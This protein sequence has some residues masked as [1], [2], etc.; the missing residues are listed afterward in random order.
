VTSKNVR[1]RRRE[2]LRKSVAGAALAGWM[3]VPRHV[4]GGAGHTPPSEKL[5]IA[6]IG[7][8][9]R[10]YDDLLSVGS[11]NVVALC[12]VD[13]KRAAPTFERFPKARRYHDFRKL[14]DREEKSIDAV[15]VASTDHTHI[16]ASVMAMKRGK[17][18][19]CEKPMGHD[20]YEVRAATIVARRYGVATQLGNGAHSG[21]NYRS[22]VALIKAGTIGEVREVHAWCDQSWPPGD[23]PKYR[24]PV[25]KHL[26]WD[27]WLGPAP[28]RPYHPTYHPQG[29]RYW[30][31]FG[32]G[33]LGDMGCHMI[34]LPFSALDLKYPLTVLEVPADG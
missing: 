21:Y 27:L 14:F 18:V 8:G 9:G 24:P 31:D 6:G 16:P 26:H 23:R 34:D 22:M 19:Y 10:G 5:N 2:F 33:R 11:E 12:D 4:L 13:D 7:A 1:F 20:V 29:W 30:W 25:P 3:A 28:V 17:H 15:V 32:N